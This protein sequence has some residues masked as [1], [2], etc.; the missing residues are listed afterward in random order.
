MEE[1]VVVKYVL[2]QRWAEL[3]SGVPEYR[4]GGRSRVPAK[5]PAFHR[6]MSIEISLAAPKR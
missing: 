3:G 2:P 6:G 5:H 4:T 1:G